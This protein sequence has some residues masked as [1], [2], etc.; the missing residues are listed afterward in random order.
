MQAPTFTSFGSFTLDGF[1][2]GENGEE[3]PNGGMENTDFE[4]QAY[5][6]QHVDEDSDESEESDDEE[7]DAVVR[8]KFTEAQDEDDEQVSETLQIAETLQNADFGINE[9]K[10]ADEKEKEHV[11]SDHHPEPQATTTSI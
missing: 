4:P 5:S 3:D 10:V 11:T 6:G 1:S 8:A 2:S 7:G 9:K